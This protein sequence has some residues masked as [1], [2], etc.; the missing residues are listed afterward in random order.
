MRT[1][2]SDADG[3]VNGG[4]GKAA[5]DVGFA[6]GQQQFHGRLEIGP[7]FLHGLPLA[8]GTRQP[9]GDGPVAAIRSRLDHGGEYAFH[10]HPRQQLRARREVPLLMIRWPDSRTTR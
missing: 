3:L 2:S 1:D 9:Q 5:I 10:R 6:I 8:V 7:G 4:F